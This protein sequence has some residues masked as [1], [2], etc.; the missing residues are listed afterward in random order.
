M[1]VLQLAR[2]TAGPRGD[3]EIE[4]AMV[5]WV[6][7]V[8][9]VL[10]TYELERCSNDGRAG[11]EIRHRMTPTSRSHG[12]PARRRPAFSSCARKG[13]CPWQ[14]TYMPPLPLRPGVSTVVEHPCMLRLK[15]PGQDEPQ[16]PARNATTCASSPPQMLARLHRVCSMQPG[17]QQSMPGTA[18]AAVPH[19]PELIRAILDGIRDTADVQAQPDRSD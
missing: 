10:S 11:A 19:P 5:V 15:T 14:D 2:E 7:T 1:C 8:H 13:A 18:A 16:M 4:A 6:A 3:Q 17:R 9:R 12:L